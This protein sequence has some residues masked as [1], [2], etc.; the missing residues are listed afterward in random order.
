RDGAAV[1]AV[2]RG[3]EAHVVP[4]DGGADRVEGEVRR[5]EPAREGAGGRVG[6]PEHLERRQPEAPGLLLDEDAPDAELVR[7]LR[8]VAQG[9]RG[10]S[11]QGAVEVEGGHGVDCPRPGRAGPNA[12]RSPTAA[13]TVATTPATVRTWFH[14]AHGCHVARHTGAFSGA[15]SSLV[16]SGTLPAMVTTNVPTR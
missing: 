1:V 11:G 4:A 5:A 8:H 15:A 16:F 3:V 13:S 6:R 14:R 12:Q 10:V 2:R 7:Q 9:G